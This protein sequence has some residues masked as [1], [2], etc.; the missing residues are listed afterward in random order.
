MQFSKLQR[1][2]LVA[3]ACSLGLALGAVAQTPGTATGP[4]TAAAG[5]SA[6]AGALSSADRQFVQKAAM[7]GLAE[8]ELGKLAQQKAVSDQVK[9]FGEHMVQ[10]HSKA[11]DELKAIATTKG[12][13]VPADVDAK[14]KAAM[15][16]LQKLSGGEF[17]R[18]YMKQMVADHKQTVS[19]FKKQ[20]EAGKDAD[21][22]GF[23]ASTLPKLQEH[24]QMAQ[25]LSDATKASKGEAGKKASY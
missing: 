9:K 18:E 12:A 24:L 1:S 4:T 17:D 25:S 23:A 5:D 16:K 20:A 3:A 19:D 11:N 14:H 21:L 22:K 2:S 7:G 6:K 8:V 15:Q 10:D 13:P